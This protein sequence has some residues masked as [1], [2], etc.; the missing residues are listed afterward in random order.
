MPYENRVD[1]ARRVGAYRSRVFVGGS[2]HHQ[3][4]DRLDSIKATV[5][6]AG[7]YPVVADEAQL[8]NAQNIHHETM[9]L[10]HRCRLAIFEM[11][12]PSGAFMEIERVAD[13]GTQILILFSA[14]KQGDFTVSR[15]L[16]TFVSEHPYAIQLSS[17]LQIAA[18][19][20]T[21]T[22]WLAQK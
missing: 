5:L 19:K 8:E 6:E 3:E 11:S 7:L 21:V 22:D 9:V 15:M 16:S 4:R 1:A 17:Y 14:P 2:Y 12:R 13:Y 20:Q 18:A 10:L